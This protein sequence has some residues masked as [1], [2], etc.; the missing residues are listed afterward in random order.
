MDFRTWT[1]HAESLITNREHFR[2]RGRKANFCSSSS[3][4]FTTSWNLP[5]DFPED[6]YASKFE[7]TI[8]GISIGCSL[9]VLLY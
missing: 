9:N 3:C 6:I 2:Q 4:Q 1:V 8:V 7:L 5:E